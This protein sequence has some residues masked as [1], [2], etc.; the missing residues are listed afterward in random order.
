[1]RVALV[2]VE[3]HKHGG[4]P[5]C[6]A[7]LLEHLRTKHE[8]TVFSNQLTDVDT[9]G[10]RHYRIPVPRQPRFLRPIVFTAYFTGLFALLKVFRG[11]QFDVVHSAGEEGGFPANVITSHFCQ[12]SE[13]EALGTGSVKLPVA[14]W[15]QK[16]RALDYMA[17]RYI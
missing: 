7:Y 15:G 3:V 9:A 16:L 4:V 6:V 14:T 1:M 11:A 13:L 10:I 5:L 2:A 8:I 17:N 12:R